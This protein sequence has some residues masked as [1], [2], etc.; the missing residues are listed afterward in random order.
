MSVRIQLDKPHACFTNLDII[1]GKAIFS[2]VFEETISAIVVK[3]EG[4]SRTRLAGDGM[5]GVDYIRAER[6]GTEL[7]VHKVTCLSYCSY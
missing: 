2:T 4:E 7:E 3:L 1:T 6:A 5:P